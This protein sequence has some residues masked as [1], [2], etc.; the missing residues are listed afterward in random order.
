M[1][2]ALRGRAGRNVS[3][4]NASWTDPRYSWQSTRYQGGC[5]D[6]HR[7]RCARPGP[8]VS[9]RAAGPAC[10]RSRRATN[11]ACAAAMS[12]RVGRCA[13]TSGSTPPSLAI[14]ASRAKPRACAWSSRS[15]SLLQV[16]TP[17]IER[18]HRPGDRSGGHEAPRCRE[19]VDDRAELVAADDVDAP[20]RPAQSVTSSTPRTETSATP[21][22]GDQV[23]VRSAGPADHLAATVEQQLDR[24]HTDAAGCAGDRAPVRRPTMSARVSIPSAVP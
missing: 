8:T 1:R 3:T 22:L 4:S 5:H 19:T 24:R 10:R 11:R 17:Q 13:A 15:R 23:T 18:H 16:Q 20:R 21:R 6:R 14:S 7:R 12:S 9:V 2:R